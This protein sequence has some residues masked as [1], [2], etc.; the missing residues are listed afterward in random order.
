[1]LNTTSNLFGIIGAIAT[2]IATVYLVDNSNNNIAD[3]SERANS[4]I[5]KETQESH[6][7]PLYKK[8]KPSINK[9]ITK[10]ASK[11][12]YVG[13]YTIKLIDCVN[14]T[15]KIKCDFTVMIEDGGEAYFHRKSHKGTSLIYLPSGDAKGA[16]KLNIGSVGGTKDRF[17][18][19]LP[20]GVPIRGTV[21]FRDVNT[22]SIKLLE[23]GIGRTVLHNPQ[24]ARFKDIVVINE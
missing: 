5:I 20:P 21:E 9:N 12:S 13:P 6:N 1:M 2:V 18:V 3:T 4:P 15:E 8:E 22:E 14:K 23:L 24:Y 7:I 19:R 17:G 16:Y 10:P 11:T